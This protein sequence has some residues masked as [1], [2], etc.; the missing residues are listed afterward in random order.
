M[1]FFAV[2]KPTLFLGIFP[3]SARYDTAN[4]AFPEVHLTKI[5]VLELALNTIPCDQ[6]DVIVLPKFH[7]VL[8]AVTNILRNV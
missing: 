2:H 8:K 3:A 1:V 4:G 7:P 6:C 5:F